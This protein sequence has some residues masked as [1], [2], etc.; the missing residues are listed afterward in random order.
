ML[1]KEIKN[2]TECIIYPNYFEKIYIDI[3]FS[4]LHDYLK[5]NLP[6]GKEMRENFVGTK[7][8]GSI[9]KKSAITVVEPNTTSKKEEIW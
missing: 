5:T 8:L 6:M 3:S 4:V 2:V 1:K 9:Y 7:Q